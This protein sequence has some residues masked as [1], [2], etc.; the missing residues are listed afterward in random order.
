MPELRP[1]IT[2]P[3]NG[4]VLGPDQASEPDVIVPVGVVLYQPWLGST[5][6]IVP[7]IRYRKTTCEAVSVWLLTTG[8]PP[9]FS[10]Q[11][12]PCWSMIV[13]LFGVMYGTL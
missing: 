1:D 8:L 9:E 12:L 6:H 2:K 3:A 5:C 10:A 7:F 4:V 11:L 13:P